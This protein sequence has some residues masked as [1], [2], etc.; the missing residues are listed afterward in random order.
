M[1][2]VQVPSCGSTASEAGDGLALESAVTEALELKPGCSTGLG[3][4]FT[5]LLV[6]QRVP[7]GRPLRSAGVERAYPQAST[8]CSVNMMIKS[9]L[10]PTSA[11]FWPLQN[12]RQRQPTRLE[13][14]PVRS[15]LTG[16]SFR[17]PPVVTVSR[18]SSN[19]SCSKASRFAGAKIQPCGLAVAPGTARYAVS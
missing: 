9:N 16:T 12:S 17:P 7:G 18:Y 11:C 8:F 6:A 13:T 1:P 19:S 5:A 10:E 4:S 15:S 14:L 3:P 2:T